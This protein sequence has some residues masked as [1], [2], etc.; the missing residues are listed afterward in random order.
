MTAVQPLS[1]SLPR[2]IKLL[3]KPG[4]MCPVQASG[5]RLPGKLNRAVAVDVFISPVAV[6]MVAGG[7][8]LIMCCTG[9]VGVK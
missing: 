6:R 2:L 9:A 1:Q 8:V 5:G 3:V 4:M 7:A